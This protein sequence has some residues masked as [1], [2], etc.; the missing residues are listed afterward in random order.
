M[1]GHEECKEYELLCKL[2][3]E[4]LSS[5]FWA[6]IESG[7]KYKRKYMAS[8]ADSIAIET[9]DTSF[10]LLGENLYYLHLPLYCKYSIE[11]FI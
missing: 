7:L 9:E 11:I 2:K 8:S 10:A 3:S 6:F 1:Q 5:Y 4:R